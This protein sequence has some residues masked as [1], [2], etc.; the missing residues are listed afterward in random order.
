VVVVTLNAIATDRDASRFQ[1]DVL[2]F[3]RR[4]ERAGEEPIMNTFPYVIFATLLWPV[5]AN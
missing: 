5:A 3:R 2:W 1:R 4:R